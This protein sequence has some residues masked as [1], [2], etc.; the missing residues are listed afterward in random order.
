M[1]Y[2]SMP[3][4]PLP[5]PTMPPLPIDYDH[6]AYAPS[7]STCW[8]LL[9]D[10]YFHPNFSNC[11]LRLQSLCNASSNSLNPSIIQNVETQNAQ[12]AVGKSA[13]PKACASA[14]RVSIRN[15]LR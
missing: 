7:C 9:F 3:P 1:P 5:Q 14:L 4:F 12:K 6:D 13:P 2:A 11:I 8:T 15:L 10:T